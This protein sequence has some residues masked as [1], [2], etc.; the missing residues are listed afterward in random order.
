MKFIFDLLQ[1]KSTWNQKISIRPDCLV[2]KLY[3]ET[4][5]SEKFFFG[6]N[7]C[8]YPFEN[9]NPLNDSQDD[10]GHFD[11]CHDRIHSSTWPLGSIQNLSIW[12]FKI[13]LPTQKCVGWTPFFQMNRSN[14]FLNDLSN[15]RFYFERAPIRQIKAI[16]YIYII[17]IYIYII[18]WYIIYD[19]Y[20][21]MIYNNIY[22][23][24]VFIY[25][26]INLW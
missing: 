2:H 26:Y 4:V 14:F 18:Y 1:Q 24:I 20:I 7:L 13:D 15:F 22:R 25:W 9:L 21:C 10:C 3:F 11:I 8:R 23:F 17:Y 5:Y 16:Y 6:K 12:N 19:L